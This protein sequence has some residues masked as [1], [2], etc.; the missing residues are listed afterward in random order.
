MNQITILCLIHY[1]HSFSRTRLHYK[2]KVYLCVHLF[3]ISLIL[4]IDFPFNE[5]I[6]LIDRAKYFVF[7]TKKTVTYSPKLREYFQL[8][9]HYPNLFYKAFSLYAWFGCR[10][11]TTF[12]LKIWREVLIVCYP[13]VTHLGELLYYIKHIITLDHTDI[14]KICRKMLNV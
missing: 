2:W 8:S 1:Q 4:Y 13:G 7:R 9:Y 11:A 14:G 12:K 6:K 10:L 3:S 5:L